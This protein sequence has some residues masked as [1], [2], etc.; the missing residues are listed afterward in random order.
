MLFPVPHVGI[1]RSG[2]A[3][4]TAAVS[5]GGGDEEDDEDE[6]SAKKM[7][8]DNAAEEEFLKLYKGPITFKVQ[9][10]HVADKPEWKLNGQMLNLTLGPKETVTIIKTKI[11]EQLGV[12]LAK[13]KL[14]FEGV[15]V[16]DSQ[17]LA[18]CNITPGAMVQLQLKERGGRKK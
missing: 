6:P 1:P 3:S 13:Q 9:V 12:P 5:G 2:A 11:Q 8:Q 18:A 14:Q 10:P 17:S 7:K 4:D 15:Y 16:K